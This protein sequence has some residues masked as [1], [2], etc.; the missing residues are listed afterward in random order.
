MGYISSELRTSFIRLAKLARKYHSVN[1]RSISVYSDHSG[2]T[3]G[4]R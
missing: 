4:N 3:A 2:D 1:F